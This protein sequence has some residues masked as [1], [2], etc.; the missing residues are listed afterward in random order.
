MV[1]F[2]EV[3][4]FNSLH[5]AQLD[6]EMKSAGLHTP[7][8]VMCRQFVVGLELQYTCPVFISSYETELGCVCSYEHVT[9]LE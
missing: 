6:R 3:T 4:E 9:M 2:T 8:R 5:P 7:E 1:S